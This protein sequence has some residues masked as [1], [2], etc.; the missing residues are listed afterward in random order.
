MELIPADGHCIAAGGTI[1]WCDEVFNE[2]FSH[3]GV[4]P[5]SRLSQLFPAAEERRP[6]ALYEDLDR[7]GKKRFFAMEYR[8]TAG[9][10]GEKVSDSIRIR[11][12]TLQRVLT[13]I[14]K[15]PGQ[16]ETPKELLDKVLWLLR[17]TTH[18]LAFA[19]FIARD[20]YV[21]L[22]ASKGWTEKLKSYVLRQAIAPDSPS[23]TGRSAYHRRQTAM[24][25][26][27]YDLSP[28][29]KAAISK[30]G[31]KYVVATPL[32][33]REKLAGVLTVIND[34]P[35]T[36][37]DSEALQSIC[38]QAA[39]ALS[40]KLREE[41]A[42]S[43]ADEAMLL[44]SLASRALDD[45]LFLMNADKRFADNA[46]ELGNVIG[47][48]MRSFNENV[49]LE[50]VPLK[51][52]ADFA[53]AGARGMAE[54]GNKR[55]NVRTHG[56]DGIEVSPMLKFALYEVLK[57]S[58]GHAQSRSIDADIR[59]TKERSGACRLEISDNGPGIPDEY[60]SEAFRP[61]KASM[62]NPC[63]MGLYIVKKIARL[64]GGRIWAEDRV[65]GDHRKGTSIVIIIPASNFPY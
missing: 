21:E 33:D 53:I 38:G 63:G 44:A 54:A 4:G 37:A 39:S 17:D 40:L 29:V 50:Y 34:K 1:V 15:L 25:M 3:R 16:A 18:Y 22:V 60:K 45:A 65:H 19:G 49:P 12:V 46:L 7:L 36:P 10:N 57:N 35:M 62:K 23:L 52:A 59:L 41:A 31:G 64:N 8:P 2:W 6:G 14:S 47:L 28:D 58:V 42:A 24:S 61:G 51:D 43:R 48:I 26:K 5:G 20:S 32:V 27:D 11:K 55:L 13:D 9:Q 56:L 30:L